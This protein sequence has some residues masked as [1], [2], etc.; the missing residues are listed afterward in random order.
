MFFPGLEA[1]AGLALYEDLRP[2]LCIAPT[3]LG[4]GGQGQGEQSH[5]AA[6]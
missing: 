3:S 2:T 5:R 1:M 4:L 6:Q